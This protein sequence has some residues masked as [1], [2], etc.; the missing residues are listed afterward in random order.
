MA[1]LRRSKMQ[2]F[3]KNLWLKDDKDAIAD[4]RHAH[5]NI[6]K[7][8]VV[9]IRS[10]GISSME[11]YLRDNLAVMVLEL[12]DSINVDEAMSQLSKLP[13]QSEWEEYVS[14]FQRCLASDTS[15][16]KW[17]LMDK[18]FRLP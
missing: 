4:Y 17:K 15:D 16:E 13:R 7:E 1:C 9:G 8:I 6:W 12:P 5:D 10:V 3:V 2:R 18:I 11:I 14:K